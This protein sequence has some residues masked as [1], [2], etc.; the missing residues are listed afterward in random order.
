MS[1]RFGQVFIFRINFELLFLSHTNSKWNKE[2][3]HEITEL[4]QHLDSLKI[5]QKLR[6]LRNK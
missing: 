4:R 6:D 3:E 1:R 2:M 5:E